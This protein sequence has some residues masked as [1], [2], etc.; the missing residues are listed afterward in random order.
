MLSMNELKSIRGMARGILYTVTLVALG[1]GLASCAT[2]KGWFGGGS[3][4]EPVVA[5]QA[6]AGDQKAECEA[7]LRKLVSGYIQTAGNN[8]EQN[9]SRIL[10]RQPY[11]LKEYVSYPDGPEAFEV[12]MQ[13]TE[14]RTR[15]YVADVKADKVRF[16]TRLHTKRNE[17]VADE[18]F[19]RATGKETLTFE[20]RNGRWTRVGSV[21]VA[22]KT[23]QNVGGEWVPLKE[24][25][26]LA[27][28]SE[29]ERGWFSRTWGRIVGRD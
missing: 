27:V 28:E 22:D 1:A 18:D 16:S 26:K 8:Q 21:F 14:S 7:E 6:V 11:Y 20:L 13:E 24:E 17:A 9:R 15:P 19:L 2:V 25:E 4:A 3:P 29:E 12:S 5:E 10:R 23:E